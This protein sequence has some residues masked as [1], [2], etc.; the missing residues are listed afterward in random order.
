VFCVYCIS[1]SLMRGVRRHVREAWSTSLAFL[2]AALPLPIAYSVLFAAFV[3]SYPLNLVWLTGY[4]YLY[5]VVAII[6]FGVPTFLLLRRLNLVLWPLAMAIGV[7]GGALLAAFSPTRMLLFHGGARVAFSAVCWGVS[8]LVFWSIW[9]N[10]TRR[11]RSSA[12][13]AVCN[14]PSA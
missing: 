8:G 11:S 2:A 5:S 1:A 13:T 10:G 3:G 7:L 4:L 12:L 14:V 6:V 9:L